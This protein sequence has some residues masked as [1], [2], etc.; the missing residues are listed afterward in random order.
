M[1]VVL[2]LSLLTLLVA[3]R[4]EERE[5]AAVAEEEEEEEEE[6]TRVQL[7]CQWLGCLELSCVLR[8]RMPRSAAPATYHTAN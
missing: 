3:V 7:K 4:I 6:W 1:F 8:R 5:E 2:L